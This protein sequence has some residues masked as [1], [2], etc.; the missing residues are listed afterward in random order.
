MSIQCGICKNVMPTTSFL[1]HKERKHSMVER[2][3]YIKLPDLVMLND[4]THCGQLIKC[5][6]CPNRIPENAMERHLQR[7]H[8]DCHL[9]GKK[10]LKS[11]YDKHMQQKHGQHRMKTSNLSQSKS[12]IQSDDV[13]MATAMDTL[14]VQNPS[15]VPY[16]LVTPSIN[17][18]PISFD[19]LNDIIRVNEWELHNYIRQGRVYTKDGH[20]YLRNV[21]VF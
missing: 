4:G 14:T 17:V 15:P 11:N 18:H 16:Q 9:C 2:V 6:F 7:S 10:L 20:L 21:N 5:H 13:R 3:K 1:G 12:S 8:C 19:N